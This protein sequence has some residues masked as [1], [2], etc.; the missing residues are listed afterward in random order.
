MPRAIKFNPGSI[1]YFI[2]DKA[3]SVFLLKQ[4]TVVLSYPNFHTSEE[5]EET[6]STGEFFGVKS[7][8]IYYPRE[9]TAKTIA[10]SIIIEFSA[11][12]FESLIKKN[13]G[14]IIKM[15]KVFSN[16]LR[17]VGKQ[18][19]SL[20]TSQVSSDSSEDFFQI[21]EYYLKNKKYK[22]AITV[23]KR[24]LH[25]YPNGIK[26][27][28]ANQRITLSENSLSSYGEGGGPSPILNQQT[29][30]AF[31]KPTKTQFSE[32]VKNGDPDL[33][34][35]GFVENSEEEK[36]FNNALALVGENKHKEA[37]EIFKKLLTMNDEDIKVSSSFEIG[38]CFFNMGK[39][40]DTIKHFIS[41]IDKHPNYAEIKRP[42]FFIAMSLIKIGKKEKAKEYFKKVMSITDNSDALY[43]K[44][45]RMIREIR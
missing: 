6:I 29:T 10:P 45:M 21:G 15:L 11:E 13:T 28:L 19:Q 7:G 41:F 37:F 23:Y 30:T 33:S 42:Y 31:E 35:L 1:I 17:R 5:V 40:T 24:Y 32:P 4:G 26:A 27:S 18:V 34:D 44:S 25:Y 16:Q 12:E 22:Q 8:L 38:K 43:R 3:D 39:F 9:E 14:I 2:N 20:V 36:L